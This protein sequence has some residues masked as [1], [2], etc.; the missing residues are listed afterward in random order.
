MLKLYIIGLSIL[1]VA[2]IA[3]ALILKTSL[4]SWYDL[5]QLLNEYGS[6][7]FKKLGFLDYLWL[8]IGYPLILGLGYLLGNKIYTLIFN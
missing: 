4:L 5:F 6:A 1:C 3:N 7:A 2:I 8:F